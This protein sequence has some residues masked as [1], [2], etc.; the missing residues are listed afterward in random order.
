M[1][2]LIVT[3][4]GLDLFLIV[5]HSVTNITAEGMLPVQYNFNNLQKSLVSKKCMFFN[6]EICE[7]SRKEQGKS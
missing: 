2:S 3:S 4:R 6:L 1:M 5:E 7:Q